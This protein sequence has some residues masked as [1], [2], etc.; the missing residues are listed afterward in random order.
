MRKHILLTFIS[1]GLA[2]LIVSGCASTAEI[3]QQ[4][5]YGPNYSQGY[6]DGC[7][8]GKN[9]AGSLFDQFTKDVNRYQRNSK[10]AMG[11]RDGYATCKSQ[12]KEEMK[13]IRAYQKK[14]K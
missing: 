12:W 8:S 1:F 3:M 4:Q 11:W 6:G 7:A 13:Q 9:A 10:Y 2:S 14:K 5:G